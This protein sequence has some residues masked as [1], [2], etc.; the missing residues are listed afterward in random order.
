MVILVGMPASGKSTFAKKFVQG[1]SPI[2]I[3]TNL[4]EGG[5]AHVNMDTLHSKD[6][7]IS[8]CRQALNE[9]KSVIIDNTNP[10]VANRREFTSIADS[11]GVPYRCFVFNTDA[12]LAHHMNMYREVVQGVRRIPDIAYNMFHKNFQGTMIQRI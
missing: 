4:T 11:Y 2:T 9:G 8:V 7:C 6:K 1:K 10:S 12:E 5:Y 3:I